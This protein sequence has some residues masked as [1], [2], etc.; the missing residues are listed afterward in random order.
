MLPPKRNKV[1]DKQTPLLSYD[2]MYFTIGSRENTKSAKRR[3][4]KQCKANTF[5]L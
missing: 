2:R 4:L 5:L 3:C 1:S